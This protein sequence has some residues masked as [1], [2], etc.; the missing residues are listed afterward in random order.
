MIF[1]WAFFAFMNL[2]SA[3]RAADR[4]V[5]GCRTRDYRG[6]ALN[7]ILGVLAMAV[8]GVCFAGMVVS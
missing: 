2:F 3:L 5:N 1:F 8:L 4:V 7:A 6:V